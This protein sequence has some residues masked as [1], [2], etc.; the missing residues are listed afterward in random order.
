MPVPKATGNGRYVVENRDLERRLPRATVPTSTN[1][2]TAELHAAQQATAQ[3]D[4]GQTPSRLELT[5]AVADLQV[6]LAA[7]LHSR[8][9]SLGP[10]G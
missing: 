2:R 9:L 10:C 4:Q 1:G 8:S 7:P 3:P 5:A 6:R